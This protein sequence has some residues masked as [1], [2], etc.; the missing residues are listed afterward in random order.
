MGVVIHKADSKLPRTDADSDLLRSVEVTRVL[1]LYPEYYKLFQEASHCLMAGD[2]SL[3]RQSRHYVAFLAIRNS[4]CDALI[5]QTI[6]SFL[7][8]G[9]DMSWVKNTKTAPVKLQRLREMTEIFWK[10]PW[11]LTNHNIKSLT[12]GK[13]SWT[14]SEIVQ[15][16][17]I[18]SHHQSLACFVLGTGQQRRRERGGQHEGQQGGQQGGQHG[19][20]HER[21][22]GDHEAEKRKE[23]MRWQPPVTERLTEFSWDEQGFSLMSSLYSDMANFIDEKLRSVRSLQPS[24]EN[25]RDAFTEN[26][27]SYVQNLHGINQDDWSP[28]GVKD[29]LSPDERKFLESCLFLDQDDQD[30]LDNLSKKV[31]YSRK[32]YLSVIMMEFKHQSQLL[33]F[34]QAVMKH[35]S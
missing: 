3:P 33:F 16:V 12:V 17:V 14:L 32:V 19:R 5:S 10:Y 30:G 13:E 15:A 7:A 9:G 8:V 31:G 22:Q 34:L 28:D 6:K 27:C 18:I 24:N 25:T 21:Q 26:I 29:V 2:G 4:G 23:K 1:E 20:R 11:K 35:L